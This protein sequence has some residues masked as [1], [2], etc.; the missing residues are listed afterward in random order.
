[1]TGD[2]Q[3]Q[4]I[5]A[6]APKSKRWEIVRD[7]LR[8]AKLPRNDPGAYCRGG[9]YERTSKEIAAALSHRSAKT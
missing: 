8:R 6:R 5:M 9:I 2:T 1:M 3:L 4:P 7:I